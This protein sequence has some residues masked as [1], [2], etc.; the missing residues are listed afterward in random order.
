MQ[1]FVC[2][3]QTSYNPGRKEASGS[4]LLSSLNG[5]QEAG[6]SNPLTPILLRE[7]IPTYR[8]SASTS[9]AAV[10]FRMATCLLGHGVEARSPKGLLCPVDDAVLSH[11]RKVDEVGTISSNPD[12]QVGVLV[13]LCLGFVQ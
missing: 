7:Q 3:G 11:F 12:Y 1:S 9:K 13:R 4:R 6:G 8:R 5:V 10:E 2:A